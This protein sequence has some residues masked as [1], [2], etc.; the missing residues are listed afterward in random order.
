MIAT[1]KPELDGFHNAKSME[2]IGRK[3]LA[4]VGLPE[5][6]ATDEQIQAAIEAQKRLNDELARI[7]QLAQESELDYAYRPP[8]DSLRGK[9]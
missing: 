4:A 1:L 9:N 2:D 7:A 3:L 8:S 5:L 6:E